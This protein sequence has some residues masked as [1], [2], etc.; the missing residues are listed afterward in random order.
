MHRTIALVIFS[1]KKTGFPDKS[2]SEWDYSEYILNP[3]AC[4]GIT[5]FVVLGISADMLVKLL[6]NHVFRHGSKHLIN[7]L[8]VFEDKQ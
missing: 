6:C 1:Q 7:N 5:G 2:G 3:G 8:A 4:T